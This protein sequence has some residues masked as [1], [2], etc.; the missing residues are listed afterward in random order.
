MKNF[1]KCGRVVWCLFWFPLTYGLAVK[2]FVKYEVLKCSLKKWEW[3]TMNR[4]M[5][6]LEATDRST[7]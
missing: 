5:Y 4:Y 1:Q 7:I 2:Y 6:I 3:T